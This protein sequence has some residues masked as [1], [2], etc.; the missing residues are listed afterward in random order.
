[1][2]GATTPAEIV[3]V[4]Y[5]GTDLPTLS[6]TEQ[7]TLD[8]LQTVRLPAILSDV[9]PDGSTVAISTLD[10]LSQTDWQ[11]RFLNLNT[12]E[13]EDS[14]ALSS[15]VY[16]PTLPMQWVDNQ[17][18]R[19]VQEGL[20][21]PLE[22]VSLNRRTGI[23][24]HTNIYPTEAESGEV[25]GAAPDLSRFALRIYEEEG[26]VIYLVSV[27]SLNRIEVGRIPENLE[28][29][30]PEWSE[31]GQ[32][33]VFVTSSIEE[34]N[35]Y[36]RTPYSPNLLDP[37][38][39]DALGR[40]PPEENM[41]LQQSSVKV[42][43]LTQSE[44][45]RLELTSA[46]EAGAV[47]GGATISPSGNHLLVKYL[48]PAQLTGRPHPTYLFPQRSFFRVY[49]LDG[50]LI[51]T[52]DDPIFSGPLENSASFIDDDTLLLG[53]TVG[54]NR[55]LYVYTLSTAE[56]RSLPLP[57]GAVTLENL[58]LSADG[59]EVLY[60]FS[61]VTQPPELFSVP[62]DG[63]TP[64]TQITNINAE[65]AAANAVQVNS[66]SFAT[67]HGTR[68]GF[69]IQPAAADF[70]PQDSPLVFW[71]QGGPGFSMVNEFAV[72]VEMPFNLLPNFGIAVLS[73]PL[74]GR[75]GFGADFYRSQADGNNFG[76]VDILEGVEIASQVV[77]QGWSQPEQLG[78]TGCSYGG[79]YAA[80]IIARF[81]DAFAA[82]NPQCS[83]LDA[84]TEWQLGFSS[85]LSYLTG[86]T[87]MEDPALYEAISPLYSA[88]EIKAATMIF[89]GSGD[90][91]QVDMARNFHDVMVMNDVPA[92]MYEFEGVGHSIFDIGFQR[93]A[94]QLQVDFFRQHLGRNN[95]EEQP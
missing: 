46:T 10:R 85:L 15:E 69:L 53:A 88:D 27:R 71:Q 41:F 20:Y 42:Y 25:L 83:L 32:Q 54:T 66:V 95:V 61:S 48:E 72:E 68:E 82:A 65:V 35:L 77:S 2:W 81:P 29:Q 74:T 38:N 13:L 5:E 6:E 94:A 80:Q 78:V 1:V 90:F 8:I 60:T 24:S 64:P 36:E 16:S 7:A 40:T 30:A 47:P 93:I 39:Q 4:G 23:V 86:K 44:P 57:P 49:D 11:V 12:G 91:L 50:N 17:T 37:V 51:A 18:L 22:I 59:T 43:D 19:F 56:L 73:V 84:F 14:L 3:N 79:Y 92:M 58:Q 31:S 87:P 21:G 62:L 9:S 75:E 34:R 67:S 33:V 70:P 63:S 45:L 28:I 76:Q 52:L 26:D 89:H 55:H